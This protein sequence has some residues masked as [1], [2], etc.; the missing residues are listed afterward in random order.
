M[1]VSYKNRKLEKEFC[2]IKLLK[3]RWGEEQSKLIARRLDQVRAADNLETL[4]TLPQLRAHELKGDRSGQISLDVK[5]PYRLLISP[6]HDETPLKE[7]GGLDWQKIVK[8]KILGVE[9]THG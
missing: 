9:D 3:R 6:D 5:Q 7:D 2:D 4:S 8:I 1:I